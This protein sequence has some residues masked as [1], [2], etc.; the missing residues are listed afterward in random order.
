MRVPY[1]LKHVERQGK[2]QQTRIAPLM[3][4]WMVTHGY[5]KSLQPDTA[6]LAELER[7]M[8]FELSN[9]RRLHMVMRLWGRYTALR[10]QLEE[11]QLFQC[12]PFTSV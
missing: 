3:K 12:G 2:A 10:K 8:I 11:Q 6:G 5:I 7:L 1:F 9:Q 4:N